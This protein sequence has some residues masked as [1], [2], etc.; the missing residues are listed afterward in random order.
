MSQVHYA[1]IA[2]QYDIFVQTTLDIPF[3]LAEAQ[4]TPGDLLEL[5]AGTGRVT[6]PLAEA[7]AKITC[8]DYA[9]EMLARLREKI[10]QRGLQVEIRQMDIRHLDLGKRFDLIII[11]FHAFPELTTPQDQRQAL[12]RIQAHLTDQGRFI[13]T[14]HNPPVRLKTTDGMSRLAGPFPV[15]DRHLFVWLVER[16]HPETKTVE[17]LEFFEVYDAQGVLHAKSWSAVTFHV[18]EKQAFEEQIAQ[19]GFRIEALYGD[20]SSAPFDEDTSPFMIWI[21][22]KADAPT[23]S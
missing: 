19:A 11:P 9:P 8:V 22:R 21:L 6:I 18:P 23:H 12:Q 20:Y 3:F 7:G 2:D 4:K 1:R 5:M 14:L 17:V 10:T 15:E 16:S 13:C